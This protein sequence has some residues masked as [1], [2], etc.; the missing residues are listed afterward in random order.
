MISPWGFLEDNN[1]KEK[2]WQ[3]SG[4]YPIE[5]ICHGDYAPYNVVLNGKQAVGI[6]DFDTAHPGTSYMGYCICLI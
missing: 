5:V 6:V 4:R 2:P 1:V 3:L